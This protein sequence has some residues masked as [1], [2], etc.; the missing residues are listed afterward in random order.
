M[1]LWARPGASSGQVRDDGDGYRS[2]Q[3][4]VVLLEV[5]AKAKHE[6]TGNTRLG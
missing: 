4:V 1:V 5:V 3:Q 6:G 2:W